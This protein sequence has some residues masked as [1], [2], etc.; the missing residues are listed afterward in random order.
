MP[1]LVWAD[2]AV[3]VHNKHKNTNV[4]ANPKS[5]SLS[6]VLSHFRLRY[7]LMTMSLKVTDPKAISFMTHLCLSKVRV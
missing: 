6:G 5:Q 2:T 1:L 3:D 4:N 7:E